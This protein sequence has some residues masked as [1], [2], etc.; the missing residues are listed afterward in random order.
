MVKTKILDGIIVI[1]RNEE[2]ESEKQ[3]FLGM[4][5]LIKHHLLDLKCIDERL[6]FYELLSVR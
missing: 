5:L 3:F 6:L 1:I 2:I 4:S